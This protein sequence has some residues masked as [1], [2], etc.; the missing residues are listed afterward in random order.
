MGTILD[1][2]IKDLLDINKAKKANQA[3]EKLANSVLLK[4]NKKGKDKGKKYKYYK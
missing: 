2:L 3:N 4:N 1:T